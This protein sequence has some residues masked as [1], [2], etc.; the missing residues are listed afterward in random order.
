MYSIVNLLF[1]SSLRP[2]P[3]RWPHPLGFL[4]R[5]HITQLTPTLTTA[6]ATEFLWKIL[7]RNL[8]KKL[9]LVSTAQNM[10]LVDRDGVQKSLDDAENT[11]ESPRGVDDV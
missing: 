2:S 6:G 4:P 3:F 9:L 11:C 10:Y 8:R 5:A 1:L 7:C